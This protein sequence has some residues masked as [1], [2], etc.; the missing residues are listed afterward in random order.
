MVFAEGRV[1][2]SAVAE[3]FPY[4]EAVRRKTFRRAHGAGPLLVLGFGLGFGLVAPGVGLGAGHDARD[5]GI[6]V[7][8]GAGF[9]CLA[10]LR[11]RA[12]RLL[13]LLALLSGALPGALV[14][15]GS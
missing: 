12:P 14:L 7:A 6:L 15:C 2:R 5:I 13:L 8:R 1:V 4:R 9:R 10:L 11:F 3:V